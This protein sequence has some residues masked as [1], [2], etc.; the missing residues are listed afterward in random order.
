M[1]FPDGLD[2]VALPWKERA[3]L[4]LS[5][6]LTRSLRLCQ[7]WNVPSSTNCHNIL[8]HKRALELAAHAAGQGMVVS[9]ENPRS[10]LLWHTTDWKKFL[11]ANPL[12]CHKLE[13]CAFGM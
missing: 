4:E 11:D 3:A 2:A 10:S 7:S 6:S 8:L 13:M 5:N 1:Q 9:I 12:E